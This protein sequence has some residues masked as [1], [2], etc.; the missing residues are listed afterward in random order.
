MYICICR[1]IKAVYFQLIVIICYTESNNHLKTILVVLKTR[2]HWKLH[3]IMK[4]KIEFEEISFLDY[5]N[6]WL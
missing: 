3:K 6:E 4:L 2:I 1:V 5:A